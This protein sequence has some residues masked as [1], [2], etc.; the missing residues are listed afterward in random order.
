[1]DILSTNGMRFTKALNILQEK[2]NVVKL[3]ANTYNVRSQSV[4]NRFYLVEI[5]DDI[6]QCN[7]KDFLY[8]YDDLPNYECKHILSVKT[9]LETENNFPN[10]NTKTITTQDKLCKVCGSEIIVK[11]GTRLLKY[12]IRKQRFM[13]K[14]CGYKFSISDEGFER[15]MY[16]P[17]IV[18]EALNLIMSG[19][20]LRKTANHL[21]ITYN[22][23]ISHVSLMHWVK[24]FTKIMK[25]YTDTL[26]PKISDV[27]HQ[28]EMM[29]N[30]KV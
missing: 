9:L 19:L 28:D 17:K 7:C 4:R 6:F 5:I 11:Q 1:M 20:S 23:E 26:A 2:E 3:N 27:W 15:M 8:R 16:D 12:G 22:R 30:V 18:T 14:D 21:K 13:C 10:P 29:L 25:A 24:K